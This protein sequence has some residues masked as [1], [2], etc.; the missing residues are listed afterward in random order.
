[1]AEPKTSRR[2]DGDLPSGA[3]YAWLHFKAGDGT[4]TTED[5]AS[6]IEIIEYSKSDKPITITFFDT[7]GGEPD[8][9]PSPN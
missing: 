7:A 2:I 9:N 8:A 3:A 5:Q 6:R 4:P 1:M